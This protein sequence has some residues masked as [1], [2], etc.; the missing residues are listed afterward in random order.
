LLKVYK[1]RRQLKKHEHFKWQIEPQNPASL[2]IRFNQD[3]LAMQAAVT[4]LQRSK[5]P[6]APVI[7]LRAV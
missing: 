1:E 6:L 4:V 3:M 5:M 2:A 7:A